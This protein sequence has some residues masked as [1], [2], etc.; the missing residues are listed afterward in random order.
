[1]GIGFVVGRDVRAARDCKG[2]DALWLRFG[3][4]FFDGKVGGLL[5]VHV[6]RRGRGVC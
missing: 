6:L 2:D 1:M 4:V 3:L 5:S